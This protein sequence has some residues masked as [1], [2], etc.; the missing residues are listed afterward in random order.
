MGNFK[1]IYPIAGCYPYK[2]FLKHSRTI[3]EEFNYGAKT[4]LPK[5]RKK[6]SH[7]RATSYSKVQK[8]AIAQ[9]AKGADP[10][11][12]NQE[13]LQELKR[14]QMFGQLK[15][16]DEKFITKV[17]EKQAAKQKEAEVKSS[18]KD[19]T[20]ASDR[21]KSQSSKAKK[22]RPHRQE[23]RRGTDGS[24]TQTREK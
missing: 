10:D 6:V 21:K 23:S 4:Q 11:S 5:R 17:F 20:S 7:K 16:K 14:K 8:K 19:I 2:K 9:L 18:S 22:S 3:W 12:V 15:K 24:S 13:A 1:L